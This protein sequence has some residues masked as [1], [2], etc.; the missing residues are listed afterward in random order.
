MNDLTKL[1]RPYE[2]EDLANLTAREFQ[3]L[4]SRVTSANGRPR[5]GD[6]VV[7][8][9]KVTGQDISVALNDFE[10]DALY[11]KVTK[12]FPDTACKL[13]R[14]Y[15][16]GKRPWFDGGAPCTCA[17]VFSSRLLESWVTAAGNR[18]DL[19]TDQ[20]SS[21]VNAWLALADEERWPGVTQNSLFASEQAS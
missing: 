8:I 10:V 21:A 7:I 18:M 14:P 3:G 20:Y 2:Y 9:N 4:D 11:R 12:D 16:R 13:H 15:Q 5:K 19:A 1:K 6:R 17:K